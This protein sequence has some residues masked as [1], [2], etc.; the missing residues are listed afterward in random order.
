MHGFVERCS[1]FRWFF[2]ILPLA[3]KRKIKRVFIFDANPFVL[4]MAQKSGAR[5]G[6]K[7]EKVVF[8]LVDVK[9]E[10]G[11]LIALR[12]SMRDIKGIQQDILSRYPFDAIEKNNG[13]SRISF[14]ISRGT[15]KVCKSDQESFYRTALLI[16]I[17]HWRMKQVATAIFPCVLFLSPRPWFDSIQNYAKQYGVEMIPL[18]PRLD[19]RMAKPWLRILYLAAKQIQWF[20][21]Y[22]AV[23]PRGNGQ[24]KSPHF[25]KVGLEYYGQFNLKHPELYSDFFFWQASSLPAKDLLALFHLRSDPLDS[26]KWKD[27]QEAGIRAVALDPRATKVSEVPPFLPRRPRPVSEESLPQT[28][29][30]SL[31]RTERNWLKNRVRVYKRQKEHWM[32]VFSRHKVCIYLSWC[33]YDETHCVIADA[34]REVGGVMAIYQRALDTTPLIDTPVH[35]DIVFGYS[36]LVADVERGN[37][38]VIPYF[39]ITGYLGDHRFPL[40]KERALNVREQ[41]M[42]QGAEKILAYLDENSAADSRWHTGNEFMR[43]N[44]EFLLQKVLTH[45]WLGL[46]LKPKVP[47]TLRQRLGPVKQLLEEAVA[48][49]RCYLYEEG[50]VQGSYPP[51]VAGLSADITVHG[52]LCAST[53]GLECA[54]A[55]IPTLLMDREGWSVSPL[56]NLGLGRVVFQNWEHLWDRCLE[57]W[58]N[59]QGIPGFGDWSPLLDQLDPFRDGRGA[60]RMGTYLKWMIDDFKGGCD[61]ETVMANAAERYGKIWGRDKVVSIF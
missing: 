30:N 56:Y 35:T 4:K 39:V 60:E 12:V 5:F 2:Q 7:V 15:V 58:E 9:D 53:A 43:V 61:R 38:S 26:E 6:I 31:G 46:V 49:G 48:T 23:R 11:L 36:H 45:S 32:R 34:L 33:K 18:F 27:L 14:F 54:L 16:Q 40:L 55:G 20:I 21:R 42:R 13:K 37:Q 3:L 28:L 51:A 19:M 24:T 29:L 59:P 17:C 25:P 47:S 8:R 1:L 52:H 57:H 41:L 22:R 10:E 50:K 44:Y